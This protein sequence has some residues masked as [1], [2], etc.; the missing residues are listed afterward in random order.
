MFLKGVSHLRAL[1]PLNYVIITLYIHPV[2]NL[3]KFMLTV[4]KNTFSYLGRVSLSLKPSM[5]LLNLWNFFPFLHLILSMSKPMTP[6][7]MFLIEEQQ[8]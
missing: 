6:C 8:I 2:H 7:E 5:Q 3:R 1:G 4:L